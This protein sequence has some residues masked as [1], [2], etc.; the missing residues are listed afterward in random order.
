MICFVSIVL[1]LSIISVKFLEIPSINSLSFSLVI[2]QG[3]FSFCICKGF[4]KILQGYFV[5]K[6]FWFLQLCEIG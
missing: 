2:S 1:V 4:C 5:L 6:L 3:Y